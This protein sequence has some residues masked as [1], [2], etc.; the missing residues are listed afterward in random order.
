MAHLAKGGGGIGGGT[1][2]AE[3]PQEAWAT[4]LVNK[5]RNHRPFENQCLKP[6][7]ADTG[8]TLRLI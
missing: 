1:L 6:I 2:I 4:P 5:A 8:I 7:L 3:N